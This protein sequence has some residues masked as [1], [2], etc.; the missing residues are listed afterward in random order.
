MGPGAGQARQTRLGSECGMRGTGQGKTDQ[1]KI[2][3]IIKI[4]IMKTFHSIHTAMQE[5]P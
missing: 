5:Y 2:N 3:V 4:M 1:E